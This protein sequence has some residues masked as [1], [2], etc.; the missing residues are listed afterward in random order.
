MRRRDE[1]SFLSNPK[2]FRKLKTTAAAAVIVERTRKSR[3][4][5]PAC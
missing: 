4:H 5:G 1:L 3:P 2:Y